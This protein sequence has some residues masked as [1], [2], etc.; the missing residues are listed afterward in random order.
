MTEEGA[1]WRALPVEERLRIWQGLLEMGLG[2]ELSVVLEREIGGLAGVVERLD[3]P[4][5]YWLVDA[6]ARGGVDAL[7]GL[8][9]ASGVA[10]MEPP[11]PERA[12]DGICRE[13]ALGA[14]VAAGPG[15]PDGVSE[16]WSG[17]GAIAGELPV[18]EVPRPEIGEAL[19]EPVGD[20]LRSDEAVQP[21]Q[22]VDAGKQLASLPAVLR[23]ASGVER[24]DLVKLLREWSVDG[25]L[26][27]KERRDVVEA[28]FQHDAFEEGGAAA[29]IATL[30]A[31]WDAVLWAA[32]DG[33]GVGQ[34]FDVVGAPA[35]AM[36]LDFEDS[37]GESA[38]EVQWLLAA[39]RRVFED[40]KAGARLRSAV[41]Q[42]EGWDGHLLGCLEEVIRR[43]TKMELEAVAQNVVKGRRKAAFEAYE[44][45][46][47]SDEVGRALALFAVGHALERMASLRAVSA[48]RDL[49]EEVLHCVQVVVD[50]LGARELRGALGKLEER[51]QHQ[52][53]T[54]VAG[55]EGQALLRRVE[56]DGDLD[57]SAAVE[58]LMQALGVRRLGG[59]DDS[60]D[61]MD[62]SGAPDAQ[63]LQEGLGA[64]WFA[65]RELLDAGWLREAEDSVQ[66]V[67]GD[68][69]LRPCMVLRE[70]GERGNV[71]CAVL[72][73]MVM[74]S[75]D[76][77]T[78]MVCASRGVVTADAEG[79][80]W[81]SRSLTDLASGLGMSSLAAVFFMQGGVADT[82]KALEFVQ[83]LQGCHY[84]D[85]QLR[86]W[87][88]P[89]F[90]VAAR[91][92]A[93]ELAGAVD[94][95]RRNG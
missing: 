63:W 12:G 24:E 87:G 84:R 60:G 44:L 72:A 91:K 61:S 85:V 80:G 4:W 13:L 29:V 20:A 38:L 32:L 23:R 34:G 86:V 25:D 8:A 58:A 53:M 15:R 79:A 31:P 45:G 48:Q 46:P 67:V 89:V 47:V 42:I 78:V 64:V 62:V 50:G 66:R 74:V 51:A 37:L 88:G 55:A 40:D 75:K 76:G 65:A 92:E 19:R 27:G 9:G 81:L 94:A 33:F 70:P 93:R 35:M 77:Q 1:A 7:A 39:L 54:H 18:A 30:E 11:S 17:T 95:W 56:R 26:F 69:G 36:A 73:P 49:A 43:E 57:W 22:I 82:R 71:G 41:L 68:R 90:G 6:V 28:V 16:P 52:L 59:P 14:L 3:R 83:G 5:E 21:R 2:E 10:W